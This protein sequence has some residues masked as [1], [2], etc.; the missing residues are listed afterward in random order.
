[1]APPAAMS[2]RSLA[3][4]PLRGPTPERPD[5]DDHQARIIPAQRERIEICTG[6]GGRRREQADVGGAQQFFDARA[7]ARG[8]RID[9][10]DAFVNVEGTPFRAAAV[11]A[12]RFELEDVGTEIGEHPPREPAELIR[13]VD[14]Q[15][16]RQQHGAPLPGQA[17][18]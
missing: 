6:H 15:H 1:M 14:D 11:A 18:Q 12:G 4:H 8:L 7:A 3:F 16:V 13:G 10:E 9:F 5:R 17:Q 2:S